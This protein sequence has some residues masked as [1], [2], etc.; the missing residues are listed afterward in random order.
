[1]NRVWPVFIPPTKHQ[2]DR[3]VQLALVKERN[4]E[5]VEQLKEIRAKIEEE[6]EKLRKIKIDSDQCV[7]DIRQKQRMLECVNGPA[8]EEIQEMTKI[9]LKRQEIL[10]VV[11]KHNA[12]LLKLLAEESN[13]N[14]DYVETITGQVA[15][16]YRKAAEQNAPETRSDSRAKSVS[17]RTRSISIKRGRYNRRMKHERRR[18]QNNN[19]LHDQSLDQSRLDKEREIQFVSTHYPSELIPTGTDTPNPVRLKDI[20]RGLAIK[21]IDTNQKWKV[22]SLKDLLKLPGLSASN[23]SSMD[24]RRDNSSRKDKLSQNRR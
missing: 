6:E 22:E 11:T 8:N 7:Q 23:A 19:E 12:D 13:Q 21:K 2:R 5:M 1:M 9:H 3:F 20:E 16:N 15:E 17:A 4:A 18:S 14:E 24:H 10:R